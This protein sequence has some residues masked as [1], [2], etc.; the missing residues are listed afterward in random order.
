M[1]KISRKLVRKLT[2]KPELRLPPPHPVARLMEQQGQFDAIWYLAQNPDVAADKRWRQ[3]P[4]MHYLQFGSKEGRQPVAWFDSQYYLQSNADVAKSGANPFVHFLQHGRAEGRKPN[5]F[6]LI[7]Q[8]SGADEMLALNE[9]QQVCVTLP[10]FTKTS[11]LQLALRLHSDDD[12]TCGLLLA[13][14]V[15]AKGKVMTLTHCGPLRFSSV[16]G[17]WYRYVVSARQKDDVFVIPVPPAA[18]LLRLTLRPWQGK[19]IQVRNAIVP[20]WLPDKVRPVP[21]LPGEVVNQLKSANQLNVALLA[22]E[23][24]Y[25]SFRDE[26][27][28]ITFTPD[29]WREVFAAQKPELFFCESAWSGIDPVTR[30]WKGKVY[31]SENFKHENRQV[32][33]DILA[34]CKQHK[35]PTLFWNKEDPTHYTD[36]KHD[37]VK[38]AVLFD[39]VFTSAAEC[40]ARYKSDYGV[41]HAF[42]L[43]FATNPRLFNPL[44]T[45]QRS[46]KVVFAGSWYANHIERSA[47]MTQVLDAL[48][49]QGYEPEIYDRY[50]GDPDPLHKWPQQYL[51]YVKPGLPHSDMPAVYKS[52]T[53]GLNFN[54][55]TDSETMFA[56]RVFE[57]M[58]SN[59]LVISNYSRGVEQMFGELVVFADREPKR[60]GSLDSAS[61]NKMRQQALHKVLTE[62][63]YTQRWHYMLRCI[64]YN[65]TA[66]DNSLTWC[67]LIDS[68]A[69]AAMAVS[70]FEQQFGRDTEARLLLLCSEVF[71]PDSISVLYQRYNRFGISVSALHFARHYALAQRYA[72]ITSR[73]VVVA[74]PAELP[75]AAWFGQ[76]LPHLSYLDQ[77]YAT[78]AGMLEPLQQAQQ[79]AESTLLMQ[80]SSW[81]LWLD[82]LLA[83]EQ[84]TVLRL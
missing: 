64:G 82:S 46:N 52:S 35:I 57:L 31:A 24:T 75:D 2:G 5:N 51:P 29:N 56:R 38:T 19:Q 18:A 15:D 20:S 53:F 25:N 84:V 79:T 4:A 6:L 43:P 67:A 17:K 9:T 45:A 32:L 11:Q 72:P 61:I 49:A 60:L 76:A 34:Y 22:D 16:F 63:T 74:R 33:F 71:A 73:Y 3:Q 81:P 12:K 13:E 7:N 8:L 39:Y 58:S 80:G 42:A 83:A 68:E 70:R 14:L 30:P 44:T 1:F 54:T 69:Q 78:P 59:T 28:A 41:K 62:H 27:N 65:T 23:F 55:V 47:V 36:R 40:V 21:T 26:F 37:F 66:S 50:H 77:G 48:I 10:L